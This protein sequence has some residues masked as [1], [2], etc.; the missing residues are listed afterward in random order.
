MRWK[1]TFANRGIKLIHKDGITLWR[2]R[3]SNEEHKWIIKMASLC[4]K[5]F[6]FICPNTYFTIHYFKLYITNI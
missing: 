5:Q 1:N 4:I 6:L 2:P 3:E